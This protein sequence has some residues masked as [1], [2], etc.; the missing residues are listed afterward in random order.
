MNSE[1]RTQH[2][3]KW[4]RI[5]LGVFGGIVFLSLLLVWGLIRTPGWYAPEPVP[6][7]RVERQI[8]RNRLVEA[9]QAF[10]RELLDG[11]PFKYN[12]YEKYVNEWLAMRYDLYPRID[13]V[14]PPVV[15]DPFVA[16]GD[17]RVRFAAKYRF[18]DRDTIVSAD[19][20]PTFEDGQI[21]LRLVGLRCGSMPVPNLLGA[22]DIDG[23]VE[24]DREEAWPGS[25]TIVG[26]LADGIRVGAQGWWRNGGV[27]Y[28]V[29]DVKVGDGVLALQIKPLERQASNNR[30]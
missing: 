25:P 6:T 15:T 23:Y 27:D 4:L 22:L 16:I 9:E 19:I 3:R 30:H 28:E 17:G 7:D 14:V 1:S 11:R 20:A 10:T 13:E 24:L 5:V 18:A 21:V 26:S 29:T 12:I 2:R 8:I